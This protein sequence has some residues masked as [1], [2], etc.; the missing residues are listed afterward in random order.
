MSYQ[1]PSFVISR[2]VIVTVLGYL[3]ITKDYLDKVAS[4]IK[5]RFTQ[6]HDGE[7]GVLELDS[8]ER[9]S[10]SLPSTLFDQHGLSGTLHVKSTH[11]S[12]LL[13]KSQIYIAD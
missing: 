6:R 5:L 3:R 7:I 12:K 10:I 4:G 9:I 2:W 8:L 1:N 11:R 13:K